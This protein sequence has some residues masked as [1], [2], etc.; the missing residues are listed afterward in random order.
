[1]KII[2]IDIKAT[3]INTLELE[4]LKTILMAHR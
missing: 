1:M 2:Y 4:N 3:T